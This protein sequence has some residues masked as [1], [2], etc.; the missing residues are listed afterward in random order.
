MKHVITALALLL[1]QAAGAHA[2]EAT[3]RSKHFN[4]ENNLAIQGYDPVAYFKQNKAVKGN[5]DLAVVH[6][7]I[8]YYFS[9][10]A[11]KEAF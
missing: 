6:Q 8:T 5:R 9:S 2:Q 10:A 1:V 11:N 4:I 7:G 3:W